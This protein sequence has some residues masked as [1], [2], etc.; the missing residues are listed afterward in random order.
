MITSTITRNSSHLLL[1]TNKVWKKVDF[2]VALCTFNGE[3]FI[4]EQLLSILNQSYPVSE[5]VISDDGSSDRTIEIINSIIDGLAPDS[6]TIKVFQNNLPLGIAANF[7][8][9][10]SL[11]TS[12]WIFLCDQDDV[13]DLEKVQY[14]RDLIL[15]NPGKSFLCSDALLV[16]SERKSLGYTLLGS[17]KVRS[18]ERRLACGSKAFDVFL[19]RNIATGATVV[20]NRHLF[21]RSHPF[22]TGWIH[23]EWLAI[24][25]SMNGDLFQSD[26]VTIEYRQH[27]SNSIGE[28]KQTL[29]RRISKY[30]EPR[31]ERNEHLA[32][33]ARELQEYVVRHKSDYTLAQFEYLHQT[34]GMF[35][36]F[37]LKR[38]KLSPS[39]PFRL[40]P[41]TRLF[42]AGEYSRYSRGIKDAIKDLIQPDHEH[43]GN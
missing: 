1:V 38:L 30:R 39:R 9:C 40:I 24:V 17:L 14:F 16:D 4:E 5:I 13:W 19:K 33:R 3:K 22:P 29:R 23:D 6:P 35:L 32:Q 36:E 20:L 18:K 42:F 10:I 8:R 12:R 34:A 37:H 21:E 15:Q 31:N 11:T 41:V 28:K 43:T 27:S 25:S 26:K 2:S 7:Q